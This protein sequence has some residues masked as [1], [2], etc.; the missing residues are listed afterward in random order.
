[1]HRSYSANKYRPRKFVRA[2]T[3]N[4]ARFV[5]L[6]DEH[7][8]SIVSNSLPFIESTSLFEMSLFDVVPEMDLQKLPIYWFITAVRFCLRIEIE[9]K[10]VYLA[11][12]M[13]FMEKMGVL[14]LWLAFY[15]LRFK[16]IYSFKKDL[17]II[18]SLYMLL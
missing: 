7:I 5:T 9:K 3:I 17:N 14:A 10:N 4:V 11:V 2:Q 13:Y 18:K 6:L 12:L 8:E 16:K 1:M 15:V